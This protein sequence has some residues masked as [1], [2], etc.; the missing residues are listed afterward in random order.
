M[1]ASVYAAMRRAAVLGLGP[2]TV[3]QWRRDRHGA[4]AR[5]P[6]G[7]ADRARAASAGGGVGLSVLVGAIVM[8]IGCGDPPRRGRGEGDAAQGRT[9]AEDDRG[10][11]ETAGALSQTGGSEED[12]PAAQASVGVDRGEGGGEAEVA[13]EDVAGK[14]AA[15][16]A[17]EGSGAES[18]GAA[19]PESG[20]LVA[21]GGEGGLDDPGKERGIMLGS[22]RSAVEVLSPWTAA[23]S[24]FESGPHDDGLGPEAI[25]PPD[26]QPLQIGLRSLPDSLDPLGEL[27]PWGERIAEDLLFDGLMRRSAAG[28]PWVEPAL[29]DRCEVD[30]PGA[31]KV[32]ECHLRG[33]IE[34]SDGRPL[35]ADD[36]VYSLSYGLD[37]RRTWARDR[38]G[39]S[40]LKQVEIVDKPAKTRGDA[41]PGRW[42]RITFDRRE[43]LALELIASVMIVPRRAHRERSKSFGRTPIGTGPMRVVASESD[44]LELERVPGWSRDDR[45]APEQERIS[46]VQVSD[47]AVGLTLLR[48]GTLHVLA[49]M[50]P[51]HYPAGLLTPGMAARFRAFVLTPPRYDLL[52]Y[53]VASGP[54]SSATMRF[55][56]HDAI[57]RAQIAHEI[58][59]S[60]G[61]DVEVP[62]D[63]QP[64]REIDLD[65]LKAS[66][67][68]DLEA[69]DI[70]AAPP[71]E[72][73][74]SAHLAVSLILDQLG[75]K[76]ERGLRQRAEQPLRVTIMWEGSA[77]RGADCVR[78]VRDEWRS[79]NMVVPFATASWNYLLQLMRRGEFQVAALRYAPPA[80]GDLY[81][82]FHS[83][84]PLNLSRVNDARLDAALDGY[85]VATSPQQRDAALRS[86]ADELA[87][88]RP[89]SVIHAPLE[90]MLVSRRVDGIE[91][92][93]DLPRLDR[94]VLRPIER[95]LW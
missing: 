3:P 82:F 41:D 85:R 40:S 17:V 73:D 48:R 76:V 9:P 43:P 22:S 52:V 64:P 13:S 50:S 39:L 87:R 25:V 93:A 11:A 45:E 74:A 32:V 26:P 19:E 16:E 37:P 46:F 23:R 65:A 1:T 90:V 70:P 21:N 5:G 27:D 24:I 91:F 68:S 62:V 71:R 77:G 86:I 29:A 94:L 14:D 42:I 12:G 72:R 55:A 20:E 66:G 89:V 38:I 81:T 54:Q 34:F 6:S 95:A 56:L 8:V 80:N 58:Y 67:R 2:M 15:G 88:L 35:E 49:E 51:A 53:N 78:A 4:H 75:W 79:L 28:A 10:R 44:S 69:I 57:P 84:G 30:S 92:V 60:A 59:R 47:A 33:G 18:N 61:Q 31:V 63:L 7:T 36:V 83:K